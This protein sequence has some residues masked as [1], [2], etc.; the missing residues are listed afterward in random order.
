MILHFLEDEKFTDTVIR[1]FERVS[2]NYS[3]YLVKLESEN[4]QLVFVKEKNINIFFYHYVDEPQIKSIFENLEKFKVAIF[5]N[6]NHNYKRII[7]TK[8]HSKVKIHWMCWGYDFYNLSSSINSYLSQESKRYL[9]KTRNLNW[10]IGYYLKEF[11]ISMNKLK[12]NNVLSEKA[13]KK[14]LIKFD[15]IST[16]VPNEVNIIEKKLDI[17]YTHLP[18]KY[19]DLES[20]VKTS[21]KLVCNGNNFLIG[22][23]STITNNHLEALTYLNQIN[24]NLKVVLPVA[25]GDMS[26]KKFLIREIEKFEFKETLFLKEFIEIKSY[27]EI[28]LRCGNVIMNHYRQQAMGNIIMCLF[29]GARLFLNPQNPIYDYLKSKSFIVFDIHT[30]LKRYKDLPSFQALAKH[31]R[32]LLEEIYSKKQVDKETLN[33]INYFKNNDGV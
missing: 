11:S 4:K 14:L 15:T 24:S 27:N 18:F 6:L 12:S 20:L 26:Y 3:I 23:S 21:N 16:V 25:Y 29:N 31:N 19:G 5:H 33:F 22:N 8:I 32:T 1:Q 9:N 30:D 10:Y 7:A 2:P 13:Y 17:S 28:M